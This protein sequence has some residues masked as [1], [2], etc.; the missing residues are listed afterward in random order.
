MEHGTQINL[1]FDSGN[2][3]AVELCQTCAGRNVSEYISFDIYP[4][5]LFII[6]YFIYIY[7]IYYIYYNYNIYYSELF[8]LTY[9]TTLYHFIIS[10]HNID[11]Q[12]SNNGTLHYIIRIRESAFLVSAFHF[13]VSRIQVGTSFNVRPCRVNSSIQMSGWTHKRIVQ[14]GGMP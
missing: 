8:I 7:I 2:H 13:Q 6:C 3:T 9:S 10:F 5:N 12:S 4:Y 14:G 11:S 1:S